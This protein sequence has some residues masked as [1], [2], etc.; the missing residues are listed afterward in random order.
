MPETRIDD[1]PELGPYLMGLRSLGYRT[2]DQVAGSAQVAGDLLAAYLNVDR[3]TLDALMNRIPRTP[4]PTGIQVGP[5]RVRALGVRL[6]RVPRPRRA[7]TMS[8]VAATP[9][10]P[11]KRSEEHTSELQSQFHLV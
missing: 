2:T 11:T 9:F 5:P 6:D 7:P 3:E 10:P 8:R 4:R 1:V